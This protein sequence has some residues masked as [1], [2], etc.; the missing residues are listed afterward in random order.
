MPTKDD[1]L[2]NFCRTLLSIAEPS[3]NCTSKGH[4]TLTILYFSSLLFTTGAL[5]LQCNERRFWE[6]VE[7][8][9][10]NSPRSAV[11]VVRTT[12]PR[13]FPRGL[14]DRQREA[15]NIMRKICYVRVYDK[16][17]PYEF[18]NHAKFFIGFHFCF[19]EN[20]YYHTLYYGSTNFTVSGLSHWS[21]ATNSGNYEE[22][23]AYKLQ[24]NRIKEFTDG[25]RRREKFYL[26]EV[27]EII[28]DTFNLQN[29]Q[30]LKKYVNN[31]RNAILTLSNRIEE[32]I[33]HTSKVQLYKSFVDSQILYLRTIAFISDLPGKQQTEHILEKLT[34]EF[35]TPNPFEVEA[36]M[37]PDDET[38]EKMADTLALSDAHLKELAKKYITAT[39][40][41]LQLLE[42]YNTEDIIRNFDES[43]KEFYELLGKGEYM[44]THLYMMLEKLHLKNY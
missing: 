31:Q 11:C 41:A 2:E 17:R 24:I 35:E 15:L 37:T 27:M 21:S 7:H 5:R 6:V 28:R 12:A 32:S 30:Y 34:E 25:Q 43:E 44:K 23:Y 19:S 20:I 33:S 38:A 18:L 13:C 22:F 1:A 36:L 14:S 9:I 26:T 3:Q 16:N 39:R 29:P 8:T 4:D 10:R 40:R 42:S